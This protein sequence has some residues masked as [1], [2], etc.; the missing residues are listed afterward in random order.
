MEDIFKQLFERKCEINY[1]DKFPY[2]RGEG[3]RRR[4]KFLMGGFYFMIVII[5]IWFPL[6]LF[7]FGS[8][9]GTPTK[10]LEVS[11]SLEF[12]GYQPIF[13]MSANQDALLNLTGPAWDALQKKFPDSSSQFLASY[14]NEDVVVASING[15]SFATW[16]ISPP[17]KNELVESLRETV[18]VI[19]KLTWRIKRKKKSQS[20]DVEIFNEHEVALVANETYAKIR[21]DLATMLNNNSGWVEIPLL[22]P[23]CILI[24]S[25]D[26]PRVITSLQ[27]ENP[28]NKS[29]RSEYRNINISLNRDQESYWWTV[30]EVGTPYQFMGVNTTDQVAFLLFNDRVFPDSLQFISG[31]G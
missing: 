28:L 2:P 9:V 19:V 31:Y 27:F 3:R 25:K 21:E 22:F 6:T 4:N 29:L 11:I 26:E 30:S 15:N 1:N 20:M 24:P 10:P 8:Q 17:N 16:D 23:N 7:A 18:T 5:A 14:N 13:K 12:T